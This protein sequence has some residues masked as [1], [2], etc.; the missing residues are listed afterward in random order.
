MIILGISAYYHDS[1]AALLIGNTI[2]AAA[3]EER[4]TRIKHDNGFPANACKYC[5]DEAGLTIDEIDAIVFYEKPFIKFERILVSSIA[6]FPKSLKMFLKIMPI[7]LKEK[8]NMRRLISRELK[9]VFGNRPKQIK[10]IEHHLCH[11]AFAYSASGYG[12]ADI[13]IVDAVGEW[14]TTSI[15]K[16][17]GAKIEV[18]AE[19]RFPDS[20]GLL[21]SS[22]TQFLGFKINSDEYKLMGLAPYGEKD[23]PQTQEYITLIKEIIIQNDSLFPQLNLSYFSFQYGDRMIR[24]KK[25]EQL[26]GIPMRQPTDE[27]EQSHKNLALAIQIV[28][29]GILQGILE[30]VK[31]N[32][33]SDNLCICGGVAL[34]CATNGTILSED[35]YSSIYVPFA[36]G[37]CGC[38]IGA[39]LAYSILTNGKTKYQI[40][41]Y[42]GPE[43]PDNEIE[44]CLIES[45]LNYSICDDEQDLCCRTAQLIADGFIIGWFQ[46]RMELGPRALGNRS[47][48]ADARNPEMKD[49][50]NSRIKFREAFRPFAPS[51][52]EEYADSYFAGCIKSP[53]MMFTYPVKTKILPATTHIDETARVQT[54]SESGN[55]KYY[56]LLKTFKALTGCPAILNTS[57]NIMGEPIV[58]TPSD[59]IATFQK[60]GLDYLVIGNFIVKK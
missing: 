55:P 15:M 28:T 58:C 25:W 14:A 53:Y 37:D 46:G 48:L 13:L 54:V 12:N 41:P 44:Q 9:G 43:Y 40:S 47:I 36:P 2:V 8:L 23:S 60:S 6:S 18:L 27:L 57:F 20:I 56:K 34:N 17:D 1:S 22:F 3:Q 39:A 50:V 32:R 16:A 26:F 11:A 52:M 19:Q 10:F 21:Y 51:V 59:A 42:L 38:S 33:S 5:L 35:I 4:F 29:V 45:Y 49:M 24:G 30:Y 7:W 31:A